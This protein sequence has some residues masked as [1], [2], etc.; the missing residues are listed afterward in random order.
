MAL[1]N[2]NGTIAIDEDIAAQDVR[3]I[4]QARDILTECLKTVDSIISQSQDM[5]GRTSEAISEKS[6]ELKEKINRFIRNLEASEDCINKTVQ[7]YIET[8]RKYAESIRNQMK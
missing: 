7:Y 3:K 6:L 2:T 8:D 1:K 4:S 5:K